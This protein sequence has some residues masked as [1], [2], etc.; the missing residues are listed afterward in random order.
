MKIHSFEPESLSFIVSFASDKTKSQNPDDYVK[1]AYQ[2]ATMWPDVTDINEIKKRIAV[3]GM[4]E[5]QQQIIKENLV[6][7]QA[8]IEKCNAA[9]GISAF[10]IDSLL[11]PSEII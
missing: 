5:V 11:P 7:D 2:P 4:W 1:L 3:A 8:Y 10:S 9:V 6:I